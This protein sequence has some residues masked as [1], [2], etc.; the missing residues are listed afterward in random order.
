MIDTREEICLV[1]LLRCAADGEEKIERLRQSLCEFGAFEPYQVFKVLQQNSVLSLEDLSLWLAQQPYKTTLITDEELAQMLV[2]HLE[3]DTDTPALRYEGFLKLLLPRD[4]QKVRSAALTR[5]ERAGLYKNGIPREVGYKFVRLLDQ[6][7]FLCSELA[8]R[9]RRL[10]ENS[11]KSSFTQEFTLRSFNWLQRESALPGMTHVSPL[12]LRRLLHDT[13]GA[14]S[15]VQVESLFSRINLSGSGMLS[16]NEWEQ[17]LSTS[18]ADELLSKLFLKQYST[19]CPGCGV[20]VQRE[21]G[22]CPTVR[23]VYC[24]SSFKCTTN[25]D[26]S[27]FGFSPSSRGVE[28][29]ETAQPFSPRSPSS[30]SVFFATDSEPMSPRSPSSRGLSSPSSPTSVRSGASTAASSRD[31]PPRISYKKDT[32]SLT[33]VLEMMEKQISLD[34]AINDEKRSLTRL[35]LDPEAAFALL[36]RYSKGYV[37]DTDIWQLLHDEGTPGHVS[38]S[39]VCALLREQKGSVGKMSLADIVYMFCPTESDEVRHVKRDMCDDETRS[40]LYTL[41][42]TT[43]C[44]TCAIPIQRTMEGCPSVT[45]TLCYTSFRCN[46]VEHHEA[47][48]LDMPRTTRYFVQKALK[49]MI[50]YSEELERLRKTLSVSGDLSTVLMEAFWDL[51]GH[52]GYFDVVD[53]K[54]KMS[55]LGLFHV[56]KEFETLAKRY[57]GKRRIEYSDFAHQIRPIAVK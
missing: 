20:H 1:S 50:E 16:Y 11:V 38:Y 54:V 17:F 44:P 43:P 45:C 55:E 24:R 18:P 34:K 15:R 9:R 36:D 28:L 37:A 51:S 12:A 42:H 46:S 49:Q 26:G 25:S 32:E 31:V 48:S 19:Q 4:N 33:R 27:Q 52:K 7:G 22:A 8:Q 2:P 23:C 10:I 35:D 30:K 6:E 14:F 41:K 47:K 13:M 3:N 39:S 57:G 53:V 5:G 56:E 21:G 29:R 40:I